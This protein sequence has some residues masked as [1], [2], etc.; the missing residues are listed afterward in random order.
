MTKIELIPRM[1]GSFYT[2]NFKNCNPMI[3]CN[4]KELEKECIYMY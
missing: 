2:L 1:Q 4:W 3:N